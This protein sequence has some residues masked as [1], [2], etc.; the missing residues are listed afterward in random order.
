MTAALQPAVRRRRLIS[1]DLVSKLHGAG[2]NPTVRRG[3][4]VVLGIIVMAAVS[5]R[6][7]S[8]RAPSPAGGSD[9][10]RRLV[11]GGSSCGPISVPKVLHCCRP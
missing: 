4:L 1:A 7:L 5:S 10:L 9:D 2:H 6:V 11:P 3:A 8:A